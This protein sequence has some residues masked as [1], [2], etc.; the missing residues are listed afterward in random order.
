MCSSTSRPGGGRM[1]PCSA[2]TTPPAW[3][4]SFSPT[5][6]PPGDFEAVVVDVKGVAHHWTKHNSFPWTSTPGGTWYDRGVVATNVTS[7]GPGLVQSK[8]GRIGV[9]KTAPAR[10]DAPRQLRRWCRQRPVPDRRHL[11]TAP[12]TRPGSATSSCVSAVGGTIERW[13]RSNAGLGP[14]T[15]VGGHLAR[16]RVEVI[17][18]AERVARLG[19]LTGFTQRQTGIRADTKLCLAALR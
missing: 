13:W 19:E 1:A 8:L 15:G 5:G 4:D 14:W 11:P 18:L 9:R 10:L 17:G 12:T 6:V 3:P 16:A 2:R 7:G